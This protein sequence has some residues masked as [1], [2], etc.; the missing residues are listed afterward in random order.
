MLISRELWTA[1]KTSRRPHYKLAAAIGMHPS[2]FSRLLS[3]ALDVPSGDWRVVQLARLLGVHPS[4]AFE[5]DTLLRVLAPAP[6]S[7][8]SR[9][10]SEESAED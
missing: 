3:G 9:E 8:R 5:R 7:P 2:R 6:N 4:R 10:V 1:V